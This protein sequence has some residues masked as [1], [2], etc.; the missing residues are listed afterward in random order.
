MALIGFNPSAF[1]PVSTGNAPSV[2]PTSAN[3]N[4]T[5]AVT[6]TDNVTA[7]NNVTN[8]PDAKEAAQERQEKIRKYAEHLRENDKKLALGEFS[9]IPDNVYQQV[10][11]DVDIQYNKAIKDKGFEA[12]SNITYTSTSIS[13]K[14][15]LGFNGYM[16]GS[17]YCS[18]NPN[19][20]IVCDDNYS[21]KGKI[22]KTVVDNLETY[23]SYIANDPALLQ[24][25]LD[26]RY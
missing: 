10:K 1:T 11:N 2:T 24:K 26:E 3:V 23:C 19:G 21:V 8:S 7:S 6:N 14:V 4:S 9:T 12:A 22:T 5:P 13:R 15:D 16:Q 25:A 18:F 17:V 20:G